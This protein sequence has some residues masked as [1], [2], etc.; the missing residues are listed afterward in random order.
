MISYNEKVQEHFCCSEFVG[1]LDIAQPNTFFGS[2]GTYGSG[3]VVQ[4][5]IQVE[6]QIITDIRF[7]A[8]GSC[9]TIAAANWVAG[10]IVKSPVL[11][12]KNISWKDICDELILPDVRRHSAL[13]VI[14]AMTTAL[15]QIP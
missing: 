7:K 14:D 9:A 4:F 6:N 8:H 15:S 1:E 5:F 3:D 2:A 13:L 11:K 10:K 12:A